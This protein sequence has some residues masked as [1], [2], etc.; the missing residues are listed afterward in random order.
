MVQESLVTHKYA[1]EEAEDAFKAV[2]QQ[3]GIKSIIYGPG[4]DA[5]KTNL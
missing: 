4:V 5:Q 1:F 3:V 2:S